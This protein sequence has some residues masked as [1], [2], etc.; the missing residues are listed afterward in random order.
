MSMGDGVRIDLLMSIPHSSNGQADIVRSSRSEGWWMKLLCI[1]H[2][3]TT[4]G[5]F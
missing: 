5:V 2:F 1:Q 3:M 4:S